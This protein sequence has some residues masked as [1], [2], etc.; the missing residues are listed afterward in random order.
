MFSSCFVFCQPA[1]EPIDEEIRR[2]KALT[3]LNSTFKH[4]FIA[5]TWMVL[6][7]LILWWII[8]WWISR[9]QVPTL[10]TVHPSSPMTFQT[11]VSAVDIKSKLHLT[12]NVLGLNLGG[13]K[14]ELWHTSYAG[15]GGSPAYGSIASPNLATNGIWEGWRT[16]GGIHSV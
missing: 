15:Y 7:P 2:K 12:N 1:N 3:N 9:T 5:G 11:E 14:S 6:D 8:L 4:S 10:A 16:D 13:M